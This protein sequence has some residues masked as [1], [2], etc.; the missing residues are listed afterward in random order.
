MKKKYYFLLFIIIISFQSCIHV[1][2]ISPKIEINGLLK[3]KDTISDDNYIVIVH[4]IKMHANY[5]FDRIKNSK[6]IS[7]H[8][9]IKINQNGT[10]NCNIPS[11]RK[12]G[13]LFTDF[14]PFIILYINNN[15]NIYGIKIVKDNQIR[16]YKY[17]NSLKK[18]LKIKKNGNKEKISCEVQFFDNNSA[19][20]DMYKLNI[21]IIF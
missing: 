21:K 17:N 6:N 16:Y 20:N 5:H 10:F 3:T 4:T 18:M 15:E 14:S 12:G 2:H 8:E 11:H 13:L 9:F 7:I 1:D 19:Y